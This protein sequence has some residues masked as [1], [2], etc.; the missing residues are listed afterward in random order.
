MRR[1]AHERVPIPLA[2]FQQTCPMGQS[3]TAAFAESGR[4]CRIAH[5]SPNLAALLAV[6]HA[7][8]AVA[9]APHSSIP[10]TL[11]IVGLREGFPDLPQFELSIVR[12]SA[13]N[14]VVVNAM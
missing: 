7:G 1:L 9:A 5:S 10:D 14:S 6:P 13:S 11:R 4:H 12:G 8:L 2:V 3:T